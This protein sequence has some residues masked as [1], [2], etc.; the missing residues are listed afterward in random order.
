LK[1]PNSAQEQHQLQDRDEPLANKLKCVGNINQP[2]SVQESLLA[3][4]ATEFFYS[5]QLDKCQTAL[6][7]LKACDSHHPGLLV[8][9]AVLQFYNSGGNCVDK[10]GQELA[11]AAAAA[12]AD[13]SWQELLVQTAEEPAA[14][15]DPA[16]SALLYNFALV[17]HYQR[18]H[19]E[20]R[21]LLELALPLA[22]PDC[23]LGAAIRELLL[24]TL[25]LRLRLPDAAIKLIDS[26]A[27]SRPP[28]PSSPEQ[29]AIL[30]AVAQALSPKPGSN[31]ACSDSDIHASLKQDTRE[32]LIQLDARIEA[33]LMLKKFDGAL[34]L[35]TELCTEVQSADEVKLSFKL[36][37]EIR[38][39]QLLYFSG[40]LEQSL[41]LLR[42]IATA[43]R[44]HS[45]IVLNN[46]S[47]VYLRQGKPR[48][49]Q[50]CLRQALQC[51]VEDCNQLIQQ[52]S[53]SAD[54]TASTLS[55][56]PHTA[57]LSM[58]AS[59]R[60]FKLLHNLG[61]ALLFSGRPAQAFN[62]L[63]EVA[64]KFPGNPCL[65]L[66]LA[67]CCVHQHQ[68]SIADR[69]CAWRIE[70]IG[71]TL[72][73]KLVLNPLLC[74]NGE[75]NKINNGD[76]M[77]AM[78]APTLEFGAICAS[79]AL[80]LLPL[81]EPGGHV[82]LPLSPGRLGNLSS[83]RRI[84]ELRSAALS[85]AAYCALG[86]GDFARAERCC[87]QLLTQ[88]GLSE[89]QTCLA[90]DYLAQALVH[91]QVSNDPATSSHIPEAIQLLIACGS[92]T[93]APHHESQLY[94][95][96]VLY[97]IAGDLLSA[98]RCVDSVQ[99]REFSPHFPIMSGF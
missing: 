51:Q 14:A 97:T 90:R 3:S 8:N 21:R 56:Q 19:S 92:C 87:R 80:L 82:S 15:Q 75:S 89:S 26:E 83:R 65:W 62:C 69:Q 99:M 61:L 63:L 88:P 20:A 48:L 39:A 60:H 22:P 71:S 4:Q 50:H 2:F 68:Q 59:D 52:Q 36:L 29:A 35:V 27:K 30:R 42:S 11:L 38:K 47:C 37:S 91:L 78:P 25:L 79:N 57:S 17:L 96:A 44:D 54:E 84:L 45:L 94:N 85:V 32:R 70:S 46:L 1:M 98:R 12:A 74:G 73:R 24:D 33:S 10:F 95:L 67:E 31:S 23:R 64:N 93:Q 66:R 53:Q 6:N 34:S 16:C 86:L 5:N 41:S 18:R 9:W 7:W 28:A 49:A 77:A 76:S 43:N 13:S 40:S 81:T 58:L 72:H 55:W